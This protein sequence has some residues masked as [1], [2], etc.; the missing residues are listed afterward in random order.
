M[1]KVIFTVFLLSLALT[2]YSGQ[3][4]TGAKIVEVANN[5]N[6]LGN[7]FTIRLEGGTWTTQ[8]PTCAQDSWVTFPVSAAPTP[9]VHK[10]AFSIALTAFSTGDKVR[11]HNFAEDS[12]HTADFISITK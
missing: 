8:S 10:Q 7:D 11:V 5:L 1:R 3:L 6:G 12:C 9:E 4:V 2:A